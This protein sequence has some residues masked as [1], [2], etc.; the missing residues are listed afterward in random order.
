MDSPCSWVGRLN[1][2]HYCKD[3]SYAQINLYRSDP[4]HGFLFVCL[5]VCFYKTNKLILKLMEITK[6]QKLRQSL[7]REELKDLQC[8]YQDINTYHTD[9]IT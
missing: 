8:K 4:N 9:I 6:Q 7:N 3:V 1:I 5:L 2:S